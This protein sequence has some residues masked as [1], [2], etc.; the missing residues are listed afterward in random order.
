[1][2][3]ADCC[4]KNLSRDGL[5]KFLLTFTAI[6]L[7]LSIVSIFIRAANTGR[8]DQA[9][10]YLEA[11]NNGTFVV[12]QYTD[13]KK[14]GFFKDEDYCKIEGEYLKKPSKDVNNQGLFK[15]W[16]TVE[17]I[18]SILRTA[19]TVVFLA[20]IYFVF[21]NKAKNFGNMDEEQKEKYVGNLTY[22]LIF[23]S[24]MIFLSGLYILIRALAINANQ[25]IGLY[26]DSQQNSFESNIA[27]N[28]IIDI[29]E[30]VLY[31]IEICFIIRLKREI[32]TKYPTPAIIQVPK[33]RDQIIN[34]PRQ[35][36]PQQEIMIQQVR[37]TQQIVNVQNI[38]PLDAYD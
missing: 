26:D 22:L 10:E 23:T 34:V 5:I 37:V 4:C 16:K 7:I 11:R 30:I 33:S 18:L 21:K 19:I 2:C 9:L 15:K 24:F 38:H 31:G 13:C 12:V 35:D 28:Y 36:P 17:I 6:N 20:M 8:Y 1:M 27:V 29:I 14:S 3:N 32:V 25:D